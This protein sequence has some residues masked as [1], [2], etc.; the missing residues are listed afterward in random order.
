MKRILAAKETA[1]PVEMSYGDIVAYARH[2]GEELTL[3]LVSTAA[4]ILYTNRDRIPP[5]ESGNDRGCMYRARLLYEI[6]ADVRVNGFPM[7][8][9]KYVGSQES[10]YEPYAINGTR[11][12]FDA[13]SDIFEE[14]GGFLNT[15]RAANGCGNLIVDGRPNKKAR[16]V[17]HDMTRR[18]CPGELKPWFRDGDN[19]D[20]NFVYRERFI[21]VGRTFNGDD[22][23]LGAYLGGECHGALDVDMAMDSL[24]YAPFDLDGLAGRKGTKTW[25]DGSQWIIDTGHVMEALVPEHV[26]LKAGTPYARGARRGCWWHPHSHFGLQIVEDGTRYD[27]DPWMVFWQLF[28]DSKRR[29]GRL[30]AMML[31]LSPAKTGEPVRFVNTSRAAGPVRVCWTFGD[32][33]WS[34]EPEARHAYARPGIYAA[35]LTVDD[36]RERASFTQ[37]VTVAGEMVRKPLL[38]IAA[39]DEPSF[40]PRPLDAMDVY[41]EPVRLMPHTLDFLS[42]PSRPRPRSRFLEA[43]L[44]DFS[45]APAAAVRCAVDNGRD[46]KWLS[47]DWSVKESRLTIEAGVDGTGMAPGRYEAVVSVHVDGACSSPQKFR[48]VMTVTDKP[49]CTGSV[50]VDDQDPEFHCTP[51]FWIGH[52]FHGWGWPELREAEGCN[53]FYRINGQ[54]PKEG[55]FARFTPD[56]EA[57]LYDVWLHERTPFAS[58]PPANNEPAKFRVRVVHADGETVVWMAPEKIRGFYPRPYRSQDRWK[59]IEPQ[60]SRKIGEFRFEE[61][62]DGFVEILA[63]DASGQVIADAVRFLRLDV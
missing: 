55:E 41:G 14:D 37:H 23:Y 10:F 35:T 11:I 42:R 13:V 18:I 26:P 36:G 33:A 53:H 2:D 44:G 48:V 52:R 31:P 4:R 51:Y 61:G 46:A 12:W 21:D 30:R 25:P 6:T 63:G 8:L 22:C 39:P 3:E 43:D 5:D 45:S 40:R 56:L 15:V 34:D 62:R 32:G 28:E 47:L 49:P 54:R 60:P 7:V 19:R 24:M 27:V 58:G 20:G 17:F 38:T 9:R 50:V 29:D 16:F 59:W 1:T 57:G